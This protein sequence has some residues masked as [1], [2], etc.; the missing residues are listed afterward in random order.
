MTPFVLTA[1]SGTRTGWP[2]PEQDPGC[3]ADTALPTTL[4]DDFS[5]SMESVLD[6][7]IESDELTMMRK[8]IIS[9]TLKA[10]IET[11]SEQVTEGDNEIIH[12]H[13]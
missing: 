6:L 4:E 8:S 13:L 2:A 5:M 1:E 7:D 3:V 11:L 12:L 9:M 10:S